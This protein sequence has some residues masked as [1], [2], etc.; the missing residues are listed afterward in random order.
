M[1]IAQILQAFLTLAPS[2]EFAA[3]AMF[4]LQVGKLKQISH[5]MLALE[6]R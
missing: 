5:E 2:L 4:W 6:A 1:E 3:R